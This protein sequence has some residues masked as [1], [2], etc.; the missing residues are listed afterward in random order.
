MRIAIFDA[1]TYYLQRVCSV[2]NKKHKCKM[3]FVPLLREQVETAIKD[4]SFSVLLIPSEMKELKER[5]GIPVII[6]TEDKQKAEQYGDSYIYKYGN[7]DKLVKNITVYYNHTEMYT[8]N[9]EAELQSRLI[10]Y[11][12]LGGGMGSST[13]A[14]GT[15]VHFAKSGKRVLYLCLKP[16]MSS[17]YFKVNENNISIEDI[18]RDIEGKQGNIV[19][20]FGEIEKDTSNVSVLNNY[21][22]VEKIYG[23]NEGEIKRMLSMI[24]KTKA[25]DIIVVDMN[26]STLDYAKAILD[27]STQICLVM[28]G[29]E[30]SNSKV[31]KYMQYVET[32]DSQLL[33]KIRIIFNKFKVMPKMDK[34]IEDKTI[35]GVNYNEGKS[36]QDIIHKLSGMRF[37]DDIIR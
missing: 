7:A 10:T 32:I 33:S 1:D 19:G 13:I 23:S 8:L 12:S 16:F 11:V 34:A 31:L 6:L 21:R 36:T 2:M 28:D 30:Q 27:K 22:N 18:I 3:E 4:S 17:G 15:A 20:I 29:T 35:G 5:A 14:A 9:T 26:F 37:F 24:D 25:Y